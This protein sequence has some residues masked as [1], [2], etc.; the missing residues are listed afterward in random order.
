MSSAKLLPRRALAHWEIRSVELIKPSI[1]HSGHCLT[2]S[3]I[4]R[5]PKRTGLSC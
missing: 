2:K 4:K 5:W 3:A 1:A